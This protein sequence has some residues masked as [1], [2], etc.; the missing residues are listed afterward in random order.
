[1]QNISKEEKKTK[2]GNNWAIDYEKIYRLIFYLID[3]IYG[4]FYMLDEIK[5]PTMQYTLED[6]S[7]ALLILNKLYRLLI[8]NDW[9]CAMHLI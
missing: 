2:N 1:M 4:L 6:L 9:M 8:L 7:T 5:L 3:N